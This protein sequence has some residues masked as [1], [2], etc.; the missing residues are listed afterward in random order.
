MGVCVCVC[1]CACVC[2][3]ITLRPPARMSHVVY[4]S[5]RHTLP[6]VKANILVCVRVRVV[7]TLYTHL[8]E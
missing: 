7:E 1:V 3:T 4:E 2:R 6:C 8:Q 5:R